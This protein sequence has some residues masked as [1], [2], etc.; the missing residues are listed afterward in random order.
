MSVFLAVELDEAVRREVM[1][2]CEPA[3][4]RVN[5]KWLPSEKLHLTLVFLGNP[6]ADQ[7]PGLVEISQR[8]VN[9]RP[10]SLELVGTGTFV[11]ARAPSVLWL[12]VGGD[13]ASLEALQRRCVADFA[14]RD[15]RPFRPHVTLARAHEDDA[16]TP[17][18]Q[19]LAS[20]RG[21]PF[22]VNRL[23]LYESTHHRFHALTTVS[24]AGAAAL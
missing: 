3:R 11:T 6:A 15:E 4:A 19:E 7:L 22:E 2:A 24:L 18:A 12:G 17:V 1:A 5:A 16:L 10:F 14:Q 8:L 20:F 9:V 13:L 23:V 21:R